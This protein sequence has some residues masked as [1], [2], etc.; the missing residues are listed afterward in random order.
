MTDTY[1]GLVAKN[2]RSARAA[3]D[4]SQADVAERMRAFGF[5]SWL[6]QTM[7]ASERA[8]RRVTAEEIA[9]LAICLDVAIGD[10]VYPRDGGEDAQLTLP[11]GFVVSGR[12]L[13][14]NDRSITWNGNTPVLSE[15]SLPD[16]AQL[17]REGAEKLMQRLV[18]Q[19]AEKLAS[20]G[21]T[22]P[23]AAAQPVVAAIVTSRLGVLVGHRHDDKPPW[24]FIAGEV[25]PGEQP[26]DAAIREVKEETGLRIATGEVIGERT[27]PKTGRRMIYI[28]ARPTHGTDVIVGDEEELAEVRWVGLAV[29]DQLL[30]GMHEPVREYLA[31]EL[32]EYLARELGEA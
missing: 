2:L 10:L 30:P 8:R 20:E 6:S 29:A 31:R 28:A 3:A 23:R 27:H 14:S 16:N 12:R 32:G 13:L 11:S 15:P 25:E 18:Q 21:W 17:A 1:A 24:T 9:A 7:S 22:P 26:E 5:S 4:L 19:A